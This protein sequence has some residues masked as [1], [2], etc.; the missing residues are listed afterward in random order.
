M[1]MLAETPDDRTL[2]GISADSSTAQLRPNRT[3]PIRTSLSACIHA[4]WAAESSCAFVLAELDLPTL[5]CNFVRGE[6]E[7]R[8]IPLSNVS[9]SQIG[10]GFSRLSRFVSQTNGA[11]VSLGAR[12]TRHFDFQLDGCWVGLEARSVD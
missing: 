5:L 9:S 8:S 2:D 11:G 7:C 3:D 10:P 1:L 4:R 6:R 12:R